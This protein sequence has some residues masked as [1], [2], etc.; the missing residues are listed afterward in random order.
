MVINL[1][2]SQE[3]SM[4]RTG[5]K[6]PYRYRVFSYDSSKLDLPNVLA[7]EDVEFRMPSNSKTVNE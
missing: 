1:T 6:S 5:T 7:I 4:A 2:A 3:S